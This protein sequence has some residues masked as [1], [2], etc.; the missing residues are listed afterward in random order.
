MWSAAARRDAQ[1]YRSLHWYQSR[2]AVVISSDASL[3]IMHVRLVS[4]R[5]VVIVRVHVM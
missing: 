3:H 4:V 1:R 2:V 5:R